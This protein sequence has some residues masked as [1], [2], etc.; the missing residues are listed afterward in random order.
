MRVSVRTRATVRVRVRVRFK[1]GSRSG[2]ASGLGLGLGS[3]IGAGL[4]PVS[5]LVLGIWVM[6]TFKVRF[7]T[8]GTV[9]FRVSVSSRLM[10]KAN[11]VRVRFRILVGDQSV[12]Y[13]FYHPSTPHQC[14]STIPS[15]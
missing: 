2:S 6:V 9:R 8:R 7:W 1:V 4:R 3:E 5:E 13:D 15:G 11:R 14:P 10:V 12:H